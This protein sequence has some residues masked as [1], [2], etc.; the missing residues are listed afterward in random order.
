MLLVQ[1]ISSQTIIGGVTSQTKYKKVTLVRL[2]F[3]NVIPK[4]DTF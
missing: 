3:A 4:N 1:P 2:K